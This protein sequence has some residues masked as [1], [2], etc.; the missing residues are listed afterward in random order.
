[1]LLAF[2]FCRR[3][4]TFLAQLQKTVKDVLFELLLLLVV[5]VDLSVQRLNDIKLLSDVGV[6]RVKGTLVRVVL[7][8]KILSDGVGTLEASA[9]EL[10][11]REQ[12]ALHEVVGLIE[13]LS[14]FENHL[15]EVLDVGARNVRLP[16]LH[17][18][19]LQSGR[20]CCLLHAVDVGECLLAEV[21][22]LSLQ[23][24]D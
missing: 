4:Q 17:G 9:E 2:I 18:R 23:L 21:L 11:L 1:M 7:V 3:R 22:L 20:L 5:H 19:G 8:F 13:C 15:L 16:H 10:D 24:G 6:K 14:H 12:V